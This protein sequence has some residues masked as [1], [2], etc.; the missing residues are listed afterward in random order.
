MERF[1]DPGTFCGEIGHLIIKVCSDIL[2]IPILVV[3]SLPG[4]PHVP[5]DPDDTLLQ[6]SLCIAFTANGPGHYDCTI[7]K[8]KSK[9][10]AG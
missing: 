3:T 2:K 9:V 1:R 5:S 7:P 6:R 8:A 4:C 10:D